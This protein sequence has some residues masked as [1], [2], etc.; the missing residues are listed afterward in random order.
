M[1]NEK[2]IADCVILALIFILSLLYYVWKDLPNDTNELESY[3]PMFLLT[4]VK[5][6]KKKRR[7]KRHN[8]ND[9]LCEDTQHLCDLD[10]DI[11]DSVD[12]TLVQR[13]KSSWC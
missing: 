1:A 3:R 5:R 8:H 4:H 9:H 6:R 2:Q 10:E 12:W 7:Q 13:R 11:Y